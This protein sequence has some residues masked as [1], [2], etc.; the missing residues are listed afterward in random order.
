MK[1]IHHRINTVADLQNVPA[2]DGIEVDVRYHENTLILHH[3]PFHHHQNYV[4]TLEDL[5]AQWHHAG[6]LILNVKTEGIEQECIDLMNKYK[7][8]SWFFLDLSMPYFA[9]YAQKAAKGEIVGFSP[10][11][12]C[13]RFSEYE[14]I[15]YALGF[16]KNVSWVWVDCF[17]HCPLDAQSA[18]QLRD[19]G[20]KICLVSP[21]LQKHP[22]EWIEKFKQQL[23]G[24]DVEAV[25]TKY[26]KLWQ[27][28][29]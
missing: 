19:A 24:I 4:H 12:L 9:A 7:I 23:Q 20:F 14:D 1:Y 29:E 22:Q 8:S 27:G 17:T 3:D 10:E 15:A 26:P 6:P 16:A 28:I 25:C 5:L 21:E 2:Q 18:K 13:A 11:N